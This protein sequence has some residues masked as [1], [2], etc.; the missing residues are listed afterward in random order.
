MDYRRLYPWA[1]NTLLG[2]TSIYTSYEEIML[3]M[4]SEHP[5]KCILGRENDRGLNLV[6]YREGELINCDESSD[7]DC[8]FY[9]FYTTVFKKVFL[10]LLLYNIEKELLTEINV[11]LAQLHPSSWPFVRGFPFSAP[12]SA[13]YHHWRSSYTSLR[14]TA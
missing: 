8:L 14:P 3:Y 10:Y 12:S 13:I 5:K 6:P 4:K 9:Y 7:P 2:E 11:T 1:S